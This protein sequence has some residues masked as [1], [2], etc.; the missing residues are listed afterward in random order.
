MS[1]HS[2][3]AAFAAV[4]A[5]VLAGCHAGMPPAFP[6]DAKV[7]RL[8]AQDDIPTL[9]PAVG[10]DTASW[11]FEQMIFDTLVRYSDAG[12]NLVPDAA[13]SWEVSPDATRFVFHLRR[14]LRFSNGRAVSSGDIKYEIERVLTPATGSQGI[15]YFREIAGAD[16][17]SA[18]RAKTVVG[19]ETPDPLTI[20]FRLAA[21]DPIFLDKLAMP[22]AAA[23][24]REV[25]ARWGEDFAR[26]VV[27][28]GPFMLKQ[29]IG[30][31]RIALARNP[32]YGGPAPALDGVVEQIGVDEELAWLKFRAGDIDVSA[33]PAAEFPHVMKTPRLRDLALHVVT[34][35][36][37][38]LGMNC[39]M[40]PFDDVRV[41]R[42]LN[43]AIDK[44][45]LIELLNGRG[46]IAHGILPPG[47]PGHDRAVRGYPYDPA[48]A[49][50]LLEQAGMGAKF[51]PQL[52]MRADPTQMMI[53]E[54]IQQDLALVGMHVVLKPVA[55]PPLLDAVRQPDTAQLFNF[56]WEADFPDPENFLQVL[57][58]KKQ[59]GANNDTFYYNPRVDEL[60]NL[61]AP[62]SDLKRRYQLYDQAEG[63]IM[64]DA[65]WVPLYH[66]VTYVIRQPWVH[67]YALNPMRPARFDGVWLSA[68][69]PHE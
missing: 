32:F 54:S 63:I 12:V 46:V 24:P 30:G 51:A 8:A 10:Y 38:Y 61:A 56:G 29:W 34:L 9:D 21:P 65:P 41:R 22:F 2:R 4:I 55:W 19:I 14:G 47:I 68:R 1:R 18:G 13:A 66:P 31:Q 60:L 20:A 43:Y 50:R 26:H 23:V 48:I 57:F 3:F 62:I 36:T 35:S 58:S 64:A 11:A 49:R 6:P 5:V 39:R 67:G 25:V 7:L 33:I 17:F 59:W 53:G 42:A 52:W 16:D 40:R 69:P 15:E 27:G 45:K 44:R 28:S 37:F